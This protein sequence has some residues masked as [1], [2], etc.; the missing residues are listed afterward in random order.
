[1]KITQRL[2]ASLKPAR[3]D[4]FIWDSD[5]GAVKG[6]GVRVKPSGAI[7][8]LI[9]YR[10]T[11]GLSRR[12]TLGSTSIFKAEQARA[13]AADKLQEVRKGK[14]P[15][16]ERVRKRQAP[17]VTGLLDRYVAEHVEV[18]NRPTTQREVKRLIEQCIKPEFGTVKTEELSRD[19]VMKLHRKLKDTP[20]QANQALAVLS[21]AFNLAELWKLRP[22]NSNPC[23]LVKR[24]PETK[25]ERFL[26][27]AELTKLGATLAEAQRTA[28]EGAGVIAAVRLLLFT[29]CRLSEILNLRWAEVDFEDAYLRLPEGRTKAGA[30]NVP[31]GAPA[32]EVLNALDRQGALVLPS[33]RDAGKPLPVYTM[34]GAWR[35]LR[36]AAGLDGVRLH[37]LRHTSGTYAGQAGANAFLVRDLLGHRTL[38]M[39]GR[40]VNRDADPLK[41]LAGRVSERIA[42][43]MTGETAAVVPMVKQRA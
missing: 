31:L 13:E 7:S 29:G 15:A 41:A 12:Y 28:T 39:T 9:Q 18:H 27:E 24:Y 14:D 33:V 6:F 22:E 42:A 3:K 35:R 37:D 38:A 43:A 23:R 34:E 1:M 20:R 26:S 21:K 5:D 30:R 8:Y 2:V 16:A 36:K 19:H 40:Y 11:G 17:T 10:T 32:L 4:L 25:R